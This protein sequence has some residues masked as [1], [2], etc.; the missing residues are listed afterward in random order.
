M[1]LKKSLKSDIVS[2]RADKIENQILHLSETISD[3][4]DFFKPNKSQELISLDDLFQKLLHLIDP[5]FESSSINIT[6]AVDVTISIETFVNELLQVLLTF[7]KNS[8]E[9]FSERDTLVPKITLKAE[10]HKD[11]IIIFYQD[12]AGGI[13]KDII[14]EIFIPYFSTKREKQGTGLGLY[15]AKTVIEEHCKGEL[16][17]QNKDDGALFTIKLPMKL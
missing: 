7:I 10:N 1:G 5:S 17:A 16:V 4:R 15:M 11:L 12:N 2:K 8:Q 14:D 6:C 13:S 3:F 9:A